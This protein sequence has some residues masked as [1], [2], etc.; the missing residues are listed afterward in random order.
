MGQAVSLLLLGK[1][2]RFLLIGRGLQG[3]LTRQN[4]PV[5]SGA[6]RMVDAQ[7]RGDSG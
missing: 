3:M 4:K 1:V 6:K 5:G 7:S 2:I